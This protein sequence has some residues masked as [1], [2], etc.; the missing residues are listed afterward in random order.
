MSRDYSMEDYERDMDCMG[1]SGGVSSKDFL[2][3]WGI[4]MRLIS[5]LGM[6]EFIREAGDGEALVREAIQ[7]ESIESQIEREKVLDYID[8]WLRG[9]GGRA[10]YAAS[11]ISSES[12]Q[13]FE[14]LG[15]H[16]AGLIFE[17]EET[18]YRDVVEDVSSKYFPIDKPEPVPAYIRSSDINAGRKKRPEKAQ[19]GFCIGSLPS[20]PSP[21]LDVNINVNGHHVRTLQTYGG[22]ITSQSMGI[23]HSQSMGIGHSVSM[24]MGGTISQA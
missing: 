19:A 20:A 10:K 15:Q 24:G 4:D 9:R 2:I 6:F 11:V 8:A 5:K 18:H 16:V 14:A 22:G 3:G 21:K 12:G 23:S 17:E 1:Q 7:K 13:K